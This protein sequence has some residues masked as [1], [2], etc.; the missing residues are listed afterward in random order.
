MRRNEAEVGDTSGEA[1]PSRQPSMAARPVTRQ[2]QGRDEILKSEVRSQVE[3]PPGATQKACQRAN[4]SHYG[5][6]A[7]EAWQRPATPILT[8]RGFLISGVAISLFTFKRWTAQ[9]TFCSPA[10][11]RHL[12]EL[13]AVTF[14][15]RRN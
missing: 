1:Q 7:K 13:R 4:D 15:L 6:E 11:D 5:G 3:N 10:V 9:A 2:E 12:Q 14:H 8:R